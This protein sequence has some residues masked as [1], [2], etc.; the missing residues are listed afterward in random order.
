LT[1]QT[2]TQRLTLGGGPRRRI[3]A[4]LGAIL[5]VVVAIA[6]IVAVGSPGSSKG[7]SSSG[8][9]ASGAT[10]V[11]RRDLVET[12]TESG[13]LGYANQQTVYNRLSGTITYLPNVGTVVKPGAALYQVNGYPVILFA[14]SYPAYRDLT[15]GDTDGPDIKELNAD[16]KT[17]GFDPDNA[18][19]VDNAW[20]DATTAAVERFQGS[21]GQTETG[22]LSLG[23]IVFLPGPQLINAVDT[24]LGS[25][26]GSAAGS[27]A[28]DGSDDSDDASAS[29]TSDPTST[30]TPSSYPISGQPH[31]E[32]VDLTTSSTVASD[33]T[34]AAASAATS[35]SASAATPATTSATTPTC[36]TTTT[37]T[38]STDCPAATPTTPTTTPTTPTT[39]TT[40]TTPLSGTPSTSALQAI[41][42]L[43]QTQNKLLQAE[44]KSANAS[45]GAGARS[46]TGAASSGSSVSKGSGSGGGGG[47]GSSA[48]SAGSSGS[49]GSSSSSSS[50][51]DAAS[52]SAGASAQSILST[53]STDLV[54]TVDLDA[55][56]QSEA[57]LHEPVTVELPDGTTVNGK[58]SEVSPIAT[59]TSSGSS[60]SSPSSSAP[61][62]T[63][64]VTITLQK[65]T[66]TTALDQAAVSVN[67]E[68]QVANN[69]L[70]VPVTAL[71]ATQGGGYAVQE[72][73][74][75]HKLIPVTPGLFAAGY[76]QISGAEV[77]DGMQVTDSQ[78]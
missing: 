1:I 69:V 46:S 54:V 7:Q 76:V 65:D 38:P 24:T 31:A 35:A 47:G 13:T 32:F 68:E 49:S 25:T 75:P 22:T 23:Q 12:D 39:P 11:Q 61:S 27:S 78:G 43:L 26:G 59:A 17:M 19:T 67:F 56:K 66:D 73:A 45:S 53:S 74:A 8:S 42:K 51:S 6:I 9:T 30:A 64:P 4:A 15:S 63:I 62:A 41:V 44:L 58:I 70:S 71:L 14:G 36:P 16:L 5:V 3:V 2:L 77:Q 48:A 60:S 50:S 28:S 57:K 18:I 34:P 40:S 21:I 29:D 37:T 72:A 33:S 55:T 20:Q 10:A 52:S